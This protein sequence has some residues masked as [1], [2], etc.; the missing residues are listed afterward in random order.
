VLASNNSNWLVNYYFDH[1]KRDDAFRIAKEM[2]VVHSATGL[3]T[4]GGLLE[5]SG[6]LDE[7]EEYFK[8]C[9]E[10][11]DDITVLD[12]FYVRNRTRSARYETAARDAIRR[13]FPNDLEAAIVAELSG[14]PRDGVLITRNSTI[15]QKAGINQGDILVAIDGHRLHNKAQYFFLRDFQ[16]GSD[17]AYI[18]WRKNSYLELKA[19]LPQR[20]NETSIDDY[21]VP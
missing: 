6:Q 3:L 1:G 14:A 18:I 16:S 9:Q 8:K 21:R 12:A 2:A 17:I 20:R 19:K 5:R 7:A 13:V 11:Y 10:R 4:M 15:A